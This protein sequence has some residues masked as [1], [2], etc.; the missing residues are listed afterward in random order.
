MTFYIGL[1]ISLT[2][3]GMA[4]LDSNGVILYKT[5]LESGENVLPLESLP[6]GVY[7]LSFKNQKACHVEYLLIR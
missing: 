1:D 6:K 2:G 5:A 4:V 3:T 7:F